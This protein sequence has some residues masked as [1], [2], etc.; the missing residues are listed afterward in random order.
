[1]TNDL[2]HSSYEN[3]VETEYE[4]RFSALGKKINFCEIEF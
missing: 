1:V 2:H 4:K 3:E